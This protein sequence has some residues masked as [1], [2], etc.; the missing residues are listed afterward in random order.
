MSPAFQYAPSKRTEF[1]SFR[2]GVGDGVGD[3]GDGI[4]AAG[5][6]VTVSGKAVH[7]A[8]HR[9]KDPGLDE[10][11]LVLGHPRSKQEFDTGDIVQS[12]CGDACGLGRRKGWQCG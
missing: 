8:H 10:R 5:L 12:E 4:T 1:F 6:Q 3:R 7:R 9:F 11:L 2:T